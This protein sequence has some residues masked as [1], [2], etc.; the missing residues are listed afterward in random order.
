MGSWSYRVLR[1][2]LKI[3]KSKDYF[4]CIAEVYHT[5]GKIEMWSEDICPGGDSLAALKKDLGWMVEATCFPV[6]NAR[7]MK[8]GRKLKEVEV[9]D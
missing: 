7:K 1:N 2:S 6:L 9:K 5:D 3:G 4:Y 8:A